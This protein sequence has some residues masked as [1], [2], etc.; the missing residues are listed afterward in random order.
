MATVTCL[1][2]GK[3]VLEE[4]VQGQPP[5][6]MWLDLRDAARAFRLALSRD[7][8]QQTWWTRRWG[9]YHICALPPH[10][11]YLIDHAV[12]MGYQPEHNFAAHW[13]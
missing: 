10:P 4:E 1:R 7:Q 2:L 5:D 9:L 6:L 3:L 8:S 11:K 13:G 12:R